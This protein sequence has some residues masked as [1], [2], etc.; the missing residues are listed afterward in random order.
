[1]IKARSFFVMAILVLGLGWFTGDST[2]CACL[3]TRDRTIHWYEY[4][5]IASG[6][7]WGIYGVTQ[8]KILADKPLAE[9]VLVNEIDPGLPDSLELYNPGDQAVVLTGWKLVNN[10]LLEYTFPS[11]SMQP[12]AYVVVEENG[13]PA[14]NTATKLYTGENLSFW[15]AHGAVALVDETDIGID[16]VRW[17]S[18]SITPP[19]GTNWTGSNPPEISSGTTLGRDAAS[20][21]TD[22]GSDWHLV[23]P[24]LGFQNIEFS[25]VFLPL[26]AR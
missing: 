23:V 15:Q 12:H 6:Q 14:N 4:A 26:I 20:T 11:F 9:V 3:N 1:M 10:D 21:D 5:P 16:F 2:L 7:S 17:G 19:A 22:D 8:F 18:S 13:N 25:L 24:T